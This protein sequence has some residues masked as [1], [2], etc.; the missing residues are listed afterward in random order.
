L[1][2]AT[3]IAKICHETL[4]KLKDGIHPDEQTGLRKTGTLFFP[5]AT[6]TGTLAKKD[7]ANPHFLAHSFQRSSLRESLV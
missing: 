5:G 3:F 7:H 2:Q 1:N 6:A 4:K